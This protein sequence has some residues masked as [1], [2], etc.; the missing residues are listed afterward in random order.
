MHSSQEI[1]ENLLNILLFKCRCAETRFRM[2][3]ERVS[4]ICITEKMEENIQ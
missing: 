4:A 2:S 1:Y 3:L